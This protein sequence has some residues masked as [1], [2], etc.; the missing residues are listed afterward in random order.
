MAQN[1]EVQEGGTWDVRKKG[2]SM[3]GKALCQKYE[4][5]V[6]FASEA[7]GKDDREKLHVLPTQA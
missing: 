4:E 2:A 5:A 3:T 7:R 1:T 6:N